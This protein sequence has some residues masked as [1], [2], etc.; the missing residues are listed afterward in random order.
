MAE[1]KLM[2]VGMTVTNK[3]YSYVTKKLTAHCIREKPAL[4]CSGY[5]MYLFFY[6][7]VLVNI[8]LCELLILFVVLYGYEIWR[9]TLTGEHS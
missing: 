6:T 4:I 3:N 1:F 8:K 5:F 7:Y 9:L 2:F